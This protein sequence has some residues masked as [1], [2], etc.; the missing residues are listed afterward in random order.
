MKQWFKLEEVAT[1]A[2]PLS[3]GQAEAGRYTF[4][5]G[6]KCMAWKWNPDM[7]EEAEVRT[8]VPLNEVLDGWSPICDQYASGDQ[9]VVDIMENPTHGCCGMV[10]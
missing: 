6:D 10:P 1:K 4:C 8:G 2:C 5:V 3:V 7:V 9:I